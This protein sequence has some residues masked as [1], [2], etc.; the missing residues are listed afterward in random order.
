MDLPNFYRSTRYTILSSNILLATVSISLLKYESRD[1]PGRGAKLHVVAL[2]EQGTAGR[3]AYP[4]GRIY[5]LPHRT[6]WRS[7]DTLW[8]QISN[9]HLY[10]DLGLFAV[11][12]KSSGRTSSYI[13]KSQ[14]GGKAPNTVLYNI[15]LFH[16]S[17]LQLLLLVTC[18]E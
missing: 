2:P 7:V 5:P 3:H 12:Q 15:N 11:K 17:I 13:V 10:L 9:L 16:E 14:N 1:H 8:V 18:H 4:V 6:T